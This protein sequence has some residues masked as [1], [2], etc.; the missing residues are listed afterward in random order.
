MEGVKYIKDEKGKNTDLLINLESLRKAGNSGSDVRSF[1]E[2]MEELE[3]IIDI[4]LSRLDTK[5]TYKS[6]REE[7]VSSG[8]LNS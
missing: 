5:K 3:D 7:L 8:K 1:I 6:V 4:E 2:K